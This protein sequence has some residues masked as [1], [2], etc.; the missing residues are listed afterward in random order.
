[1]FAVLQLEIPAQRF[2]MDFRKKRN[3]IDRLPMP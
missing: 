3:S 1:M 2:E